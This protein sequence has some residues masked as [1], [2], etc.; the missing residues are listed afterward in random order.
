MSTATA[1]YKTL[2]VLLTGIA[3]LSLLVGGI[4][5]MNIMLVSVT[6]RT[7]EIGLRKALGAPPWAIRRQFLVEATVLGLAGGVLGAALGIV[8]A[9]V[10]PGLLGIVGRRLR[11]RRRRLRRRRHRHRPGLRR[12]PRHAR[13]AAGPHRRAARGVTR[14]TPKE[15]HHVDPFPHRPRAPPPS[16]R[17]RPAAQRLLGRHR[18]GS[19][20]AAP[21][22]AATAGRPAATVSA[23][24]AARTPTGGGTSGQIASV[25]GT[26]MQVRGTDA[27]TAVTWTDDT[28]FT[29]H[30]AGT[31]ADVTVGCCVLAVAAP[32]TARR[33]PTSA[34]PTPPRPRG[35]DRPVTPAAD[36]GTCTGRFGGG[37]G[38]FGGQRPT[39]PRPDA[40]DRT[41]PSG[42]P[43]GAPG[44][45]SSAGSA[46]SP[47]ARSPPSTAAR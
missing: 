33:A 20:A 32:T 7:R 39:A 17:S 15:H 25:T 38:G 29:A 3:A 8:A 27:Q 18:G 14:R 41:R 1:V 34:T 30:V 36:D 2:T 42:A 19:A 31:L 35:D 40:P 16:P 4:G 10:L 28:T 44:G 9:Q 21:S 23:V 11:R 37:A 46:A 45:R 24:P 22:P 5:V 13:R 43:T 12:L 47:P 26:V 6:E